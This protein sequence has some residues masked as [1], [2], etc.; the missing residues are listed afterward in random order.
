MINNSFITSMYEHDIKYKIKKDDNNAKILN[1]QNA[2][3]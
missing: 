1:R 2:C 3:H